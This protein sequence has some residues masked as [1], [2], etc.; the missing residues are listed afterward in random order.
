MS[1]PSDSVALTGAA[2]SA[3][4]ALADPQAFLASLVDGATRALSE[5]VAATVLLVERTRTLGDRLAGRPGDITELSLSAGGE[6][7]SLRPAARG[8]WSAE[9]RRVSGGVVIA[10]R[11][12]TLGEWLS[13]FAGHVAA[14]AGDAAGDAAASTRALQTLGI[15]SAEAGV[16]VGEASLEA[17]LRSLPS[18]V[19]GRI[20]ADAEALVAQIIELLLDTAPRVRLNS[21]TD[22]IVRRAATVYL[23][24][25]LR[26]YL[27]LPVEW[28]LGHVFS[29]GSTPPGALTAQLT[30]LLGAVS[31]LRDAAVADDANALLVNGRFLADRFAVSSLDLR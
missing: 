24:D 14:A 15:H 29:D 6:T 10:R 17:D 31:K 27:A 13:A 7:L 8:Q 16:S 19:S 5:P 9:T 1:K 21:E 18:R 22:L 4:T 25:T 23:P 28:A 2:P 30:V 3:A 26:A 12:Q 20:P 11:T